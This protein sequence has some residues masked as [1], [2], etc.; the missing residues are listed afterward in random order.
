MHHGFTVRVSSAPG[1]GH[2]VN[3][4]GAVDVDIPRI[5]DW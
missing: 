4:A 5:Y 2:L 3:F 1:T